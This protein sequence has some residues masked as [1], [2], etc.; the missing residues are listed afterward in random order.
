MFSLKNQTLLV[1]APHPDDEVLGCAGLIK[2]LKDSGSKVFVL[3]L[4][5][6]DTKD[7]SKTGFS[8]ESERIKEIENV[9]NFLKYDDF[10]IA[11]PGSD[12]HLQLDKIGQSKVMNAIERKSK[13]SIEKVKP[14]IL[15]FPE[16]NSY[17]QDHRLAARSGH[18]SARPA[19]KGL[20]HFIDTVLSYEMPVD[21]WSLKPLELPNFYL[22]LSKSDIET[23]INAWKLYKSQL[24]SFP[25][26]RSPETV[27]SLALL[28]G[29]LSG[30]DFAEA[31]YIHRLVS[32]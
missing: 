3:F 9:A 4:T 29:S 28:R 21:A 25:S 17:N 24:R 22:P 13:V 18:A 5:N 30:T 26:P 1:I 32:S 7:F 2:K 16:I 27:K 12:Y 19:E 14:S 15:A 6:A 31:F 8:I 23:K 11:F 20:K 10:D